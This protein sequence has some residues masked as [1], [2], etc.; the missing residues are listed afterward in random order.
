MALELASQ[1]SR[2]WN[3]WWMALIW[4]IMLPSGRIHMVLA[5]RYLHLGHLQDR[6]DL[7]RY[8]ER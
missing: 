3:L 5:R 8:L 6:V 4:T 1:L 7:F 2:L